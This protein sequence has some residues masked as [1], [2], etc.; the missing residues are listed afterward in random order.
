MSGD[1][2]IAEGKEWRGEWKKERR[3][4]FNFFVILPF[5]TIYLNI[6]F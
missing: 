5:Y 2:V 3:E 6:V 4:N 1:F